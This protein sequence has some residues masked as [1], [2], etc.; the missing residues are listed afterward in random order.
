MKTI[1]AALIVKNESKIIRRCLESIKPHIDY[2][3]ICDTGSTDDT[4]EIILE[5]L[6]DLPGEL[7]ETPWSNFGQNRSVLMALA[8]GKADYL[9]LLDADMVLKVH[10]ENFKNDLTADSHFVRNEGP[11]DYSEKRIVKGSL[12]WHYEGVTH[13]HIHSEEEKNVGVCYSV[14][15]LHFC[16]GARRP[17][18]FLDDIKLLEKGLEDEP[19]NSRYKFYL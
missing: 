17:K 12:D 18:K 8:K 5:E 11:L 1:C 13:E 19:D 6:S 14:S 3:V 15:F 10:A 16:D 4:K 7:H 2:W 9:L